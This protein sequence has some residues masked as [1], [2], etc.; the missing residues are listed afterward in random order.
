MLYLQDQSNGR[1]S[2]QAATI[3]LHVHL[4]NR[5]ENNKELSHNLLSLSG[6]I[7]LT[8]LDVK[9]LGMAKSVI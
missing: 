9:G 6:H 4:A 3:W 5:A 8:E 7:L 1:I 2:H